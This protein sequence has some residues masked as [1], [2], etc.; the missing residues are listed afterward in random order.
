MS[1]TTAATE[2]AVRGYRPVQKLVH[3][4][5]VTA[6]AAQF[7][8]GYN[9]DLDDEGGEDC[10]PPGEDL[11]GGD[12]TDAFEDRLDRLEE[13]CEARAGDYDML[14]GGFDLAELHLFLGLSVLAL[15]VLRP[16]V[17][18]FAGLPPWSEH[19]SAGDRRLAGA[20]EKALMLLLVVVPLSGLVLLGT[21]DDAWLPLH[22]AAHV[23]FFAALAAHLFTNLRPAVLRRML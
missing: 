17:R 6:V 11:S 12:T 21:G 18:R 2:D 10:D 23:T 5:T 1:A 22:V 16:V 8:V 4:L 14:G 20:T 7:L 19:L 9:L 3:W 13:A 15:G